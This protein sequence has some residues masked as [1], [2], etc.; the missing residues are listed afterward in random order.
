MAHN[1][2]H[3]LCRLLIRIINFIIYTEMNKKN[4]TSENSK[5][6]QYDALLGSVIDINGKEIKVGDTIK[7]NYLY[8]SEGSSED[9]FGTEPQNSWNVVETYIDNV[10]SVIIAHMG[11]MCVQHGKKILSLKE[12]VETMPNIL[13]DFATI[14]EGPRLDVFLSE[15][16]FGDKK[17]TIEETKA[18]FA[19]FEVVNAA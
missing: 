1:G 9:F 7:W 2:S 16:V 14:H 5:P 4:D 8:W 18:L 10:T 19:Q 13:D 15:S 11:A 17:A 3:M 12:I 6:M